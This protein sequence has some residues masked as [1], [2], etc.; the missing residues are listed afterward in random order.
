MLTGGLSVLNRSRLT[1]R[2]QRLRPERRRA[3][4]VTGSF[5][6]VEVYLT[7]QDLT[8]ARVVVTLV[9]MGI[10]WYLAADRLRARV[11]HSWWVAKFWF[12]RS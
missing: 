2:K 5:V 7:K 10:V 12:I 6:P 1:G 8:V 11:G 4:I 9:S 3:V